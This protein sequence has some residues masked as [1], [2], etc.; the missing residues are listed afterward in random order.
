MS[1]PDVTLVQG[2]YAAF[3]RGD[4]AHIVGALTPNVHWES[5]GRS[6]AFPTFGLWNGPAKV[7]EFFRLVGENLDFSDFS[8]REFHAAADKVFVLGHYAATLRKTGKKVAS[9]WVHVITIKDGRV[10]RFHEFTD[11]ETIANAYR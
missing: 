5:G 4:V 2:L 7:Q 11:T 10:T 1:N 8:P 6:S 9:D 3:L